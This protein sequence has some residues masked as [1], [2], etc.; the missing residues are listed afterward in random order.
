MPRS[1]A[2]DGDGKIVILPRATAN[3]IDDIARTFCRLRWRCGERG[4][5]HAQLGHCIQNA[6]R[7][8][9]GDMFLGLRRLQ[10]RQG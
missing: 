9:M 5:L 6:K 8:I 10:I 2:P 4:V 3:A 1:I 7:F